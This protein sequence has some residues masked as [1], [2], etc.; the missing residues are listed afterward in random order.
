MDPAACRQ[1]DDVAA[2]TRRDVDALR[3]LGHRHDVARRRDRLELLDGGVV[4]A[5]GLEDLQLRLA[6]RI[7]HAQPHEEAVELA[8]GERIGALV[9]DRILRRQH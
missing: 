2:E 7:A 5:V 8:L 4:P 9:L 6:L 3:D 1:V